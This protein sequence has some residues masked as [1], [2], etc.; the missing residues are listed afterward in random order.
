LS[1]LDFVDQVAKDV[2]PYLVFQS[3][4]IFLFFKIHKDEVHPILLSEVLKMRNIIIAVIEVLRIDQKVPEFGV[5][6]DDRDE[7][8]FYGVPRVRVIGL[9]NDNIRN[10]T[11]SHP[12]RVEFKVHGVNWSDGLHDFNHDRPFTDAE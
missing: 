9:Q 10:V 6:L 1:A 7:G 8:I 5:V 11:L 12:I 2:I 3:S 4:Q